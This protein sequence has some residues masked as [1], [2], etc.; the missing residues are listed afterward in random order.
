[1]TSCRGQKHA[2]AIYP[3]KNECHIWCLQCFMHAYHSYSFEWN[4]NTHAPFNYKAL[5]LK[6]IRH[7]KGIDMLPSINSR[8][9]AQHD[10]KKIS[11]SC[12]FM[13]SSNGNTFGVTCP[14]CRGIHRSPVNS[15]HK[16]PCRRALMFSLICAW[17]DGREN[18]QEAG[19]LRCHGVHMTSL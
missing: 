2:L 6:L 8:M 15:L 10:G 19:D 12:R 4:T 9:S 18:N 7:Y 5:N 13:M 3:M 1:M 17:I 11:F 14:L 16:G